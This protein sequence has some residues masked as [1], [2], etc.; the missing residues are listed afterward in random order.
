[1]RNV[2][3]PSAGEQP[4][5][6]Y[7]IGYAPVAFTFSF[8]CGL[9]G[10]SYHPLAAYQVYA[11]AMP[12]WFALGVLLFRPTRLWP[13]TKTES[14]S[15]VASNIILTSES[16]A[17]MLPSSVLTVVAAKAGC[18]LLPDPF[19]KRPAWKRYGLAGLT[20]MAIIMASL[21]K[22]LRLLLLPA[23][24]ALAY[25]GGYGIKLH[26]CRQVKQDNAA[27]GGFLSAGQVLVL[28]ITLS[29]ASLFSH[30]QPSAPLRDWRLW[31]VA[32]ASLSCG[33]LGTRLMLH[34][35]RQGV[36]FPAYRALSL[37]CALGASAARGEALHWSGWLAVVLGAIVVLWA[38]LEAWVAGAL[39]GW[40]T[41]ARVVVLP[42]RANH[43]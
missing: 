39:V 14:L 15:A 22:P 42:V 38:S 27:K 4:I 1:M 11:L 29:L 41:W 13:P 18:L 7:I 10:H 40:M 20:I 25:V 35:T 28:A 23:L 19:D 26:V 12:C 5:W 17:L 43:S 36:A 8:L 9:L 31:A 37:I 16:L 30:A 34:K 24:L 32:L 33:L 2:S 6:F 3:I 21:N